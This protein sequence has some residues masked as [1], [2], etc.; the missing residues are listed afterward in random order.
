MEIVRLAAGIPRPPS[1]EHSRSSATI[2]CRDS[3]A[4]AIPI[5]TI[6]VTVSSAGRRLGA[7]DL[8]ENLLGTQVT[9][10]P[11]EPAWQT[12]TARTDLV[13]IQTVRRVSSPIRTH[14]IRRP[15]RHSRTS[16]SVVFEG[17]VDGGQSACQRR[18][19]R[20]RACAAVP[21]ASLTFARTIPPGVGRSN[22]ASVAHG[23][24][25][26]LARPSSRAIPRP[27]PTAMAV[28]PSTAR[29]AQPRASRFTAIHADLNFN[30]DNGLLSPSL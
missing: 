19:I 17:D 14:S 13:L 11:L 26:T 2:D 10:D 9:L 8:F 28:S 3:P 5:T 30:V 29:A 21:W 15:S 16:L 7:H 27:S 1:G 6:W 24:G 18:S 4:L 12:D 25:D 23:S 22:R 20:P